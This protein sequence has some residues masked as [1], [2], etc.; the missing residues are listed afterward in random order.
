MRILIY[1]RD[2]KTP[3]YEAT[4][5]RAFRLFGQG[6]PCPKGQVR[7]IPGRRFSFDFA[8]VEQRIAVEIQGGIWMPPDKNGNRRGAHAAPL[9]LERDH[10]KANLACCHGYRMLFFGPKDLTTMTACKKSID[11][12]RFAL[13]GDDPKARQGELPIGKE[14]HR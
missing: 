8:W 12:V 14:T 5:L 11:V 7:L 3:D 2:G 13:T 9:N 4:F 10:R 6:L 1:K